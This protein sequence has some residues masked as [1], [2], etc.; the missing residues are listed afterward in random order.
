M[1]DVLTYPSPE[2]A[3]TTTVYAVG[4]VHG[5]L[6]LLQGI[7][8]LIADDIAA[9]RPESPT[10]CYLG[11]YIDRGPHSAQVIEHLSTRSGAI[12]VARPERQSTEAA[13]PTAVF[14]KGNHEDRMLD[15]L[16]NPEEHG[17]SWLHNGGREAL[18]SYGLSIGKQA[19]DGDWVR[20]RDELQE[21]LPA[22]H[23]GFLRRLRLA[24]VWRGYLFVHAGLNPDLPMSAQD[25]H[26]MMWI[27]E[28]FL[29]ST[30]D[31]SRR[32]VHGH[33]V[34]PEPVFRANRIGIDTGASQSGRLTCLVVSDASL[35]VLQTRAG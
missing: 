10:V 3:K 17:A 29:S 32:I 28:P 18:A 30:R 6:D 13:P 25:P 35:R 2:A 4:D 24:F 14:L 21:R 20:L 19:T 22:A 1:I 15:F 34:G 5:R 8:R 33:V 27:K 7:E 9:T 26:D 31:W 23:L 12:G 16:A 11:D